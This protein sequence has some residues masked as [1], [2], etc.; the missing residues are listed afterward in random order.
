LGFEGL[1]RAGRVTGLFLSS[2]EY[3]AGGGNAARTA[4]DRMLATAELVRRRGWR[5]YVHLKVLPGADDDQVERAAALASRLSVNLEAP[6]VDALAR[7]APHKAF[8]EELLAR[9]DRVARVVAARRGRAV[10]W[11]TQFVVGAAGETDRELLGTADRLYRDRGLGRAYYSR[12][13]PVPDTP[14]EDVPETPALRQVRLYQADWLL[15]FYGFALRELPFLA[16]GGLPQDADPKSAWAGAHPEAFPIEVNRADPAM[17]LRV[18]G[19]G[20]LGV[21]RIVDARVRGALRSPRDLAAIG[22]RTRRALAWL[23]IDG[24]SFA[25]SARGTTDEHR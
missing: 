23:T 15:R 11:S 14:L 6:T 21:R 25:G 22:V 5:G 20:P 2:G 7:V 9:V 8:R 24:R 17:L 1:L 12:F 18:P 13:R 16:G 4:M 10:S 19:L 3:A